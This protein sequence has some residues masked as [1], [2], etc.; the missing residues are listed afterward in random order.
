MTIRDAHETVVNFLAACRRED[1]TVIPTFLAE[2]IV[3]HNVGMPVIHGRRAAVRFLRMLF[4]RP[5]THFD[6]RIHR[7]AVN[8]ETVLTE[9]TDV[10]IIGP[11]RFQF[12]VCGVFEVSDGE[13]TLWRDYFDFLDIAKAA[14]RA[15]VGAMIPRWRPSLAVE[16]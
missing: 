16:G 13:I 10:S 9:R 7:I 5:G 12:W 2:D 15:I 14:V 8:G 4:G 1:F 3:Y 6:V 11:L